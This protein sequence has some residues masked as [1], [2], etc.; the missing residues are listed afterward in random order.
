MDKFGSFFC[1]ERG[2]E[3]TS[4]R[5]LRYEVDAS[6][7][8]RTR[9]ISTKHPCSSVDIKRNEVACTAGGMDGR[10]LDIA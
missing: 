4:G 8:Q 5:I 7:T 2:C 1:A 6:D 10:Y 3:H 9:R